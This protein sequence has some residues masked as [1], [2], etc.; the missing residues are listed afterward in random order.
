MSIT[1]I[2]LLDMSQCFIQL[3][4]NL[5]SFEMHSH[6]SC[7]LRKLHKPFTH[8]VCAVAPKVTFQAALC[9]R[10]TCDHKLLIIFWITERFMSTWLLKQSCFEG[11]HA[12]IF[13]QALFTTSTHR[14]ADNDSIW[15]KKHK[16]YCN[17]T[18]EYYWKILTKKTFCKLLW[19]LP[20]HSLG[21]MWVSN[22]AFVLSVGDPLFQMLL[23][24]INF[25]NTE[26]P[27]ATYN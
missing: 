23:S 26:N 9:D 18:V 2:F 11:N 25:A 22:Y 4:Q 14:M 21:T 3:N 6:E 13:T 24:C 20:E 17:N 27:A 16:K 10:Q 7:L 19:I 12:C 5:F 8:R 1:H 15:K